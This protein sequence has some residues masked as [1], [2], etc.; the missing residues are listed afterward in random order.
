MLD[1]KINLIVEKCIALEIEDR[2]DVFAREVSQIKE[3]MNLHGMFHSSVTVKH[4]IEAIANEFRI[5]S[6]FIWNA[7]ARAIDTQNILLN[8]ETVTEIKHNIENILDN[9]SLDLTKHYQDLNGIMQGTGRYKSIQELKTSA[10][11]RTFNEIEYATLKQSISSGSEPGIVNIYQSYGI[12]QTGQ[13][14]TSSMSVSLE[15]SS[16]KEIEKALISAK[17]AIEQ[18]NILSP[19]NREQALELV[20]DI[21]NEIKRSK[22][23]TFRIRGALEGLALTVRT[24]GSASSAYKLIKGAA[25]L[26][27]LQLP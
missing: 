13:G 8:E 16:I 19:D 4:I 9:Q 3:K 23:N 7:F 14:S 12:V 11:E 17:Q 20:S 15:S 10:L 25:S 6:S 1:A 24:L 22:P 5:R 27:G 26:L 21:T 2:K 18:S